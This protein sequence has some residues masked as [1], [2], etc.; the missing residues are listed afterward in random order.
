MANLSNVEIV[1]N[2][3][4]VG[5]D[6]RK[7]H[8]FENL[9]PVP[10]GISYNA[11]LIK[12]EKVALV[13]G[14]VKIDFERQFFQNLESLIDPSEIDYIIINHMEPDHTGTLPTLYKLAPKAKLVTTAMGKKMLNDFYNI[15]D[16]ERIIVIK[17][18]YK[19]SLGKTELEFYATPSVHW[20]ETMMT[21]EKTNKILFSG[22]A[23][24]S[25]GSSDGRIF[26]YETDVEALLSEAK[27]YYVNIVGKYNKPTLNAIKKVSGLDIKIIAPAHGPI[28]VKNIEKII[29]FYI[30][31]AEMKTK[32]NKVSIVYGTM[33]GFLEDLV[34]T[35][36]RSLVN[37][38]ANVHIF[39]TV[40]IH[41]SYIISEIWDSEIVLFGSPTYDAGPFPPVHYVIHLLERKS[42]RDK[43]FGLFGTS[44]WSGMGYKPI[45]ESLEKLNWKLIEPIVEVKGRLKEADMEKVRELVENL[46]KELSGD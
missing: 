30:D 37:I 3:F 4:Y 11:Y 8:L 33:Y 19:I 31:L 29:N 6:D 40:N 23:F 12:D 17:D 26:D 16:D 10:N 20:P 13:E 45:K 38:G 21:Y 15:S 32:K 43:I 44:G 1:D 9:W 35:I 36:A 34:F 41:A 2:I 25:F 22:D 24:G 28:W 7:N 14:G 42:I 5:V 46:G 39:N 18:G 27:R